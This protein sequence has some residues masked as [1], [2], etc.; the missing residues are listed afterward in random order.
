M[1]AK[2]EVEVYRSF[3]DMSHGRSVILISHR[4]GCARLADRVVFLDA[5]R[6]VEEGTHDELLARSG[7]YAEMYEVQ[8]AWYR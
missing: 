5:G 7:R 4:L 1:D 8:A 6:I 2:A 3:T